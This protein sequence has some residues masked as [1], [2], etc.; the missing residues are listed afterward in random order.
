MNRLLVIAITALLAMPSCAQQATQAEQ[1]WSPQF[2]NADIYEFIK[3]VQEA[4]GKTFV[5]DPR[6]KGQITVMNSKPLNQQQLFSL[7][8]ATLDTSGFTAHEVSGIVRVLPNT[9]IKTK[10]IP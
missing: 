1:T 10:P 3:Y 6:V 9:D 8:L 5:V 7:F 4:T 2:N